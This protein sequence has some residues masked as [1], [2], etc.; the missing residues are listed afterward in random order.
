MI[1]STQEE[2]DQHNAKLAANEATGNSAEIDEEEE[3]AKPSEMPGKQFKSAKNEKAS[4]SSTS[5]EDERA[6]AVEEQKL[7]KG[8]SGKKRAEKTRD[9]SEHSRKPQSAKDK[10]L[11]QFQA[12]PQ[13][14]DQSNRQGYQKDDSSNSDTSMNKGAGEVG[15]TAK[16]V[17]P[18]KKTNTIRGERIK[19]PPKEVFFKSQDEDVDRPSEPKANKSRNQQFIANNAG[20]N[21]LLT[22]RESIDNNDQDH[23]NSPTTTPMSNP[24]K[25]RGYLENSSTKKEKKQK[26]REKQKDML[27]PKRR[28]K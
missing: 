18:Q 12:I 2:V 26:P 6:A 4:E 11:E 5:G 28:E 19:G 21:E 15:D 17:M 1:A 7:A 16:K 9:D 20:D 10:K 27:S 25:P 8:R 24:T 13:K 14:R 23:L 22:G 3:E